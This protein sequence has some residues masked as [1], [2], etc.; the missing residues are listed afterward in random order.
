M[1]P[2]NT[3]DSARD[4]ELDLLDRARSLLAT[5]PAQAIVH[6]KALV[7]RGSVRGSHE[8]GRGYF[9]LKDYKKAEDAFRIGATKNYAP[10]IQM[11]GLMFAKGIGVEKDLD[12]ARA[13]LERASRLG[14]AFAKRG[15]GEVLVRGKYGAFQMF[16]GMWLIVI[17]VMSVIAISLH[18]QNDDR[19]R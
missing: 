1:R 19:L 7:N 2:V 3:T 5:D 9:E 12:E 4:P 8:L 16:R 17:S 14:H 13:L 11:L 6:L 18:D 10:S 15:L